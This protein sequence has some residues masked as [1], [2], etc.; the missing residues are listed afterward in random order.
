MNFMHRFTCDLILQ[1]ATTVSH[2]DDSSEAKR[3]TERVIHIVDDDPRVGRLVSRMA[4]MCGFRPICFT[5]AAEFFC[6]PRATR[7]STIVLDLSLGNSDAV[8]VIRELSRVR[9]DGSVLL[10]SGKDRSI[11]EEV[12]S[13]GLSYGLAMHTPLAKPFSKDDL[14]E[15]L[16][17]PPRR[18]DPE[19]ND[20]GAERV[21]LSLPESLANGWLELWYQPKIR[22]NSL[23]IYGAEALVRARHPEHGI[24]RPPKLLPPA[25]ASSYFD[26]TNFVIERMFSDWVQHL[27]DCAVLKEVSVNVP[28]PILEDGRIIQLVRSNLGKHRSFPRLT[29]EFTEAD[30]IK[31]E[32]RFKEISYQLK[33]YNVNISM[34][35]FGTGY[36]SLYRLMTVEFNE[37][38]LDKSIVQN[39]WSDPKV[40]ALCKGGIDIAHQMGA[41]AC[42]EGVETPEDLK[43]LIELGCDCAQGFLFSKAVPPDI[44]RRLVGA[45]ARQIWTE[46]RPSELPQS[47]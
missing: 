39:C 12:V 29:I 20:A 28:A 30:I 4:E 22:L 33:L 26:L 24:V 6:G 7:D 45:T 44:F 35:D 31:N 23:E 40:R 41:S 10:I 46:D 3:N 2:M 16:E 11:L 13:I 47:A 8:E 38:K 27:S 5:S 37:I 43:M 21:S 15:H 18:N 14:R 34:D 19:S 32:K 42:A 25:G 1:P 17:E 9:Y 36:S